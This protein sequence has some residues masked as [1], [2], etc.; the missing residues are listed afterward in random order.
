MNNIIEPINLIEKFQNDCELISKANKFNSN[1]EG[2]STENKDFGLKIG[3]TILFKNGYDVEM[4]SKI[5]GFDKDG[6]AFLLWDCYWFPID[7]KIRLIKKV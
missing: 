4:I 6:D 3:D 2:F 7:L 1:V 5:T